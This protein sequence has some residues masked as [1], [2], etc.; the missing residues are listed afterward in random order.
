MYRFII[1][2]LFVVIEFNCHHNKQKA[3][4]HIPMIKLDSVQSYTLHFVGDIM[5][6]SP[7]IASAKTKPNRKTKNS[8]ND[9]NYE[10]CFRFIKP[11]FET[12]D[13]TIG[14]LEVTLS[15]KGKYSGYPRFRSPDR[16]AYD[17]KNSGIDVLTTANNHSNDN[18]LFGVLHT[19][20]Q[21][22]STSIHHIGTYR[23][24]TERDLTYPFIHQITK[25]KNSIRIGFLNY[26]YGTNGLPTKE[27][28]IVNLID[29]TQIATDIKKLDSTNVDLIIALMHWGSE[30]KL[31][32]NRQQKAI[33]KFLINKGV[34]AII[35][36]HPHVVQPIKIKQVGQK[37]AFVAYSLGN[38]ISNQQQ[39]NT[40]VGLIYQLNIEK[41]IRSENVSI[42]SHA[43][44]P[45]WRYI[46]RKK[47]K[48]KVFSILPSQIDSDSIY[49]SIGL[50]D[51]DI[52]RLRTNTKKINNHIQ[53]HLSLPLIDLKKYRQIIAKLPS[54]EN[55]EPSSDSSTVN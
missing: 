38:F 15:N 24:K 44:L 11:I 21:L 50:N 45:V 5:G 47:D 12:D 19:L 43:Y 20:D 52:K 32:E 40:D 9:F 13:L 36:A 1:F 26:T 37:K 33:S 8:L 46:H 22:D 14:N 27:P 53:N 2:S 17:L 55:V 31:N 41:H 35:G 51:T 7:Q 28:A 39:T 10:P 3:L 16:L 4:D 23:N 42:S 30:Y 48:R 29:T 54:L 49:H 6:H 18:G 34:H 25:N